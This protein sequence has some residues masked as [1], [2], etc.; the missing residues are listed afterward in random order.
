ME[1]EVR[2]GGKEE[3]GGNGSEETQQFQSGLL[4]HC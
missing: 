1:S 4:L 3:A 2:L